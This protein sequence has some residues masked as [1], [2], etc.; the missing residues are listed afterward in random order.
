PCAR[1]PGHRQ[2]RP[3]RHSKVR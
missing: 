1:R 3:R 2:G